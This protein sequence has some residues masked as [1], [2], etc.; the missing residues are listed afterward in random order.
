MS[1]IGDTAPILGSA[2]LG[3][4][5]IEAL[6]VVAVSALIAG[7]MF[8]EL[9]R[10][11]AFLRFRSASIAVQAG[12]GRGRADALREGADV[13]FAVAPDGRSFVVSGEAP[14]ELPPSIE[15]RQ[16]GTAPILFHQDGTSNGGVVGLFASRRRLVVAVSP[17]TGL[18][19]RTE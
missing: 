6:V 7:I 18:V 17:D 3:F 16:A 10:S 12:L 13:R 5:L 9:E 1:A 15:L 14:R 2:E 19:R 8:P 11:L 4:T